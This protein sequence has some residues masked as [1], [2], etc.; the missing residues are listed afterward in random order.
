MK[1]IDY[2]AGVALA[3]ILRGNENKVQ[4]ERFRQEAARNSYLMAEAMILGRMARLH[5]M[6]EVPDERGLYRVE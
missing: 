2:H 6:R 1:P 3:A 5:E 4:D